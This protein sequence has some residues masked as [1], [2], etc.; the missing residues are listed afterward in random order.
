MAPF[1][2][3]LDIK[4]VSNTVNF[5]NVIENTSFRPITQVKQLWAALVLGLCH[6]VRNDL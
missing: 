1:K 6:P 3:I 5:M 2:N 4:D